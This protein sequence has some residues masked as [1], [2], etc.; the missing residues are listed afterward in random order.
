MPLI[1]DIR[2]FALDDGP[3]IRRT[4]FMKGCPL[5]CTWCHNPE[6]ISPAAEIAFYK[7]RCRGCGSCRGVCPEGAISM[8]PE[9]E[10]V[11][12]DKCTACG[13]CCEE[14][15]STALSAIGSCYHVDLLVEM[16]LKECFRPGC[17]PDSAH[18]RDNGNQGEPR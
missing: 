1:S 15:P 17:S 11:I 16:L 12:R 9:D 10:R 13:A 8:R 18:P 2:H 3:G 5:S 14:C 7:N 4:V 6:S